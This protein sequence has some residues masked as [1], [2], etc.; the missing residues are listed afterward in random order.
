MTVIRDIWRGNDPTEPGMETY[1]KA[2]MKA[3][4]SAPDHRYTHLSDSD[5]NP[6]DALA[7]VDADVATF[8]PG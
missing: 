4:L 2:I 8:G 5:P 1:S 6:A 3:L 7:T